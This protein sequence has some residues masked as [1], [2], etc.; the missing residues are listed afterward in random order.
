MVRKYH[1]E[2]DREPFYCT[3]EYKTNL[4]WLIFMQLPKAKQPGNKVF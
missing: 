1:L 3:F 2:I 4:Q